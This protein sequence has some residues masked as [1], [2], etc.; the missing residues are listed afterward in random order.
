MPRLPVVTPTTIFSAVIASAANTELPA[1]ERFSARMVADEYGISDSGISV[2][3][4]APCI[5][6]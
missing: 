2:I 5:S 3:I 6:R 1:T 4:N